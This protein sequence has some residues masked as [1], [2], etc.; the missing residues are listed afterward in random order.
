MPDPQRVDEV[1]MSDPRRLRLPESVEGLLNAVASALDEI[2][3]DEE[4]RSV[5]AV[6]AV[7]RNGLLCLSVV[8]GFHLGAQPVDQGDEICYFRRGGRDLADGGELVVLDATL[9]ERP[10]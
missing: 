7:H 10:G 1:I 6:V 2:A 5:E 3:A 9:F 8:F 4:A